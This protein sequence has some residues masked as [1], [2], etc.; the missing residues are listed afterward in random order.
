[1]VGNEEVTKSKT[2]QAPPPAP[3]TPPIITMYIIIYDCQ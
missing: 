2:S 3:S 1:M